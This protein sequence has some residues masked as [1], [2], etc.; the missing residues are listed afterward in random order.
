MALLQNIAPY[1]PPILTDVIKKLS[2]KK[3]PKK[4]H[5][6]KTTTVHGKSSKKQISSVSISSGFKPWQWAAV[7]AAFILAGLGQYYWKQSSVPSSL[8]IGFIPFAIAVALFLIATEPWK[9]EGLSMAPLSPVVEGVAFALILCVAGFFRL[10]RLHD[11][12]NGMFMD[13]G[14]EGLLALK[15]LHEKFR[16][17]FEIQE[18]QNPAL[19]LYSLAAWFLAFPAVQYCFYL[20]FAVMGLATFPLAYW[21]VRQLSGPRFALLSLYVFA[22]MRW[23]FNFCRNGFPTVQ[24]PFYM[25]GALG[26]LLHGLKTGKRWSFVVSAFF[27]SLGLYTYNAFKL[28]PLLLVVLFVYEWF[29]NRLGIKKNLRN[30]LIFAAISL[31]L[32]SPLGYQWVKNGFGAREAGNSIMTDIKSQKSYKPVWNMVKKTTFMFNREGDDNERHNM[33]NHRMLDDVSGA[34]FV[35]GLFYAIRRWQRR[36]Y[37]YALACIAVMSLPCLLSVVPA[38]ANRMLGVTVFV[39]FLVAAPLAAVWSRVRASWGNLGEVVFL[40]LLVEPL[41]IMGYQNYHVYFVEQAAM[42][43]YWETSYYGSYSIDATQVGKALASE[44]KA[45][46]FVMFPRLSTHPTV[47]FLGY[48]NREHL[49]TFKLPEGLA[50]LQ[51]PPERGLCY[52]LLSEHEGYL[53]TLQSLY[54]NGKRQDFKDLNGHTYLYLYRIAPQEVANAK[55]LSGLFEPGGEKIISTF[56]DNLPQGPYRTTLRGSVMIPNTGRYHLQFKT[57]SNVSARIGG[58]SAS[59]DLYLLRGFY[60]VEVNLNAPAGP[61]QL[62]ISLVSSKGSVTELTPESWTSLRIG[63]LEASYYPVNEWKGTPSLVQLD[64]MINFVNGT[65]FPYT[66]WQMSVRWKGTLLAP[67]TGEY[68]FIANTDEKVSLILDGQKVIAWNKTPRSGK[69]YLTQGSHTFQ[70][71]FEKILGPTLSLLWKVPGGAPMSPIPNSAFGVPHSSLD[72]P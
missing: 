52:A 33:P 43:S 20:F 3:T 28:F 14:N 34:L 58:N 17:F 36:K 55:G 26:F 45:Y 66:N 15:I 62:K 4:K 53:K 60:P 22:V 29:A 19:L 8:A 63:G 44:G 40:L 47:N 32:I 35:M 50:P 70:L 71:D 25:F 10:Y 18:F 46:D 13:Q 39:A 2:F 69:I 68:S 65:D 37:F 59:Q 16:P 57:N 49:R 12:P 61:V 56:P 23:H 42:N 54:T 24:V 9:R 72:R 6:L 11:I 38:H 41:L 30:I 7:V 64:P 31:V 1:L 27:F 21:T 67:A 5:P 48:Q 51:T